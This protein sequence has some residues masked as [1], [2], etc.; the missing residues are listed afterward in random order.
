M[1]VLK[2]TNEGMNN[3]KTTEIELNGLRFNILYAGPVDGELVL[4][5][6]GFPEFGDAWRL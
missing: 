2:Q 3:L 1:D 5:L 4:F 6:R